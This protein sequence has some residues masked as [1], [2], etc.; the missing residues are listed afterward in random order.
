MKAFPDM[1]HDQ[2]S[3]TIFGF[4][5]Y[6]LT[7]FILFGTFFAV[8]AVLRKSV[9]G[10]TPP[11]V[12]FELPYTLWQTLIL[13]GSAYTIGMGGAFA[14]RKQASKAMLFFGIT[15]LLGVLF[16]G[17]E[18]RELARFIASGNSWQNSA[19]LSSFFTLV[20]THGAHILFGLLWMVLILISVAQDG[21]TAQTLRRLTCM[22][23]FWQF[24]NILWVFVFTIVYLMGE[25]Q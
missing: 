13:L 25:I 2:Y 18:G 8:Y 22:R 6:L 15:F 7:D 5:M 20:G 24:L 23:M 4:W 1:Y 12:L 17:L 21:I 10:G 9:L 3:R 11:D 16:L 19:F 14:H